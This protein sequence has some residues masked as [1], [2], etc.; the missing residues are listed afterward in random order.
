MDDIDALLRAARADEGEPTPLGPAGGRVGP[1]DRRW[2]L[3]LNAAVEAD[4]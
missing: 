2:G 1:L 4:D 3:R